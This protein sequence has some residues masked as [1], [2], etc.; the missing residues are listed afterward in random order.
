MS[1]LQSKDIIFS[2]Y[3]NGK[4][5]FIIPLTFTDINY[6]KGI[7]TR[8][9]YGGDVWELRV[10]LLS[11]PD[12][13]VGDVNLPSLAYVKEQVEALQ[14]MSSLPI[15]FTIRTKSQGGKFPDDASKEAL[16][17]ILLAIASGISYVDVEIDWPPAMLKEITEKKCS[18]KVVASYHSWTGKVGWTSEELMQ[19]FAAADA[20]GG[21][22]SIPH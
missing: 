20:F 13:E 17:L 8:I 14:T 9:G 10:D 7:I 6:A 15:L 18:T 22:F 21:K 2:N 5:T 11:P 3:R 4:Q 12:K 16:D 1:Q 19:R